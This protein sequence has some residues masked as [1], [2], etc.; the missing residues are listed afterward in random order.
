MVNFMCRLD[1][2]KEWSGSRENFISGYLLGCFWKRLAFESVDRIKKTTLTSLAG[3]PF[4]PPRAQIER[5]GRKKKEAWL[6]SLFL[7]GMSIFCPWAFQLL[8]L[9][10]SHS[11]TNTRGSPGSPPCIQ[12]VRGLS[13]LHT[14]W[15]N[16]LNE[17]LFSLPPWL[18]LSPFVSLCLSHMNISVLGHQNMR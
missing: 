17:C 8:V 10:P 6:S 3:H 12:Q 16:S 15:A 5:K 13:G 2:A 7:S 14:V 11:K 18:S 1:W 4:S 9:G